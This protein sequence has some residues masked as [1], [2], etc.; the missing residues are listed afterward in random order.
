MVTLI[1]TFKIGKKG[2]SGNY[3]VFR[4]TPVS[5][6]VMKRALQEATYSHIRDK[7]AAVSRQNGFTTDISHLTN[8][9]AFC[10]ETAG[11]STRTSQWTL[12]NVG[13]TRPLTVSQSILAAKLGR[14]DKDDT[15]ADTLSMLSR[16]LNTR[17]ILTYCTESSWGHHDGLGAAA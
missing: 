9:F 17:K 12:K 7:K 4:L 2:Y 14:P 8:L 6:K 3:R 13:E 5:G 16:L 11:S 10:E 1:H 15:L